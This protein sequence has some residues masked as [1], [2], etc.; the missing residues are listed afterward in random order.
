[1]AAGGF[2]KSLKKALCV[3][4]LLVV[5]T[6][7][8]ATGYPVQK[9][10]QKAMLVAA[11]HLPKP[12]KGYPFQWWRVRTWHGRYYYIFQSGRYEPLQQWEV[13]SLEEAFI[14]EPEMAVY[15]AGM[16]Q[17]NWGQVLDTPPHWNV[18]SQ[19]WCNSQR[20]P[21]SGTT[22]AEAIDLSE[23]WPG[24][25]KPARGYWQDWEEEKPDK[26]SWQH[27]DEEKPARG[28]WQDWEEEKPDKGSWQ[29][30]DE[31]ESKWQCSWQKEETGSAGASSSSARPAR[32][33]SRGRSPEKPEKGS[34]KASFS[35]RYLSRGYHS[36]MRREERHRYKQRGESIPPHLEV[37]QAMVC[38]ELKRAMWELQQQSRQNV[39]AT[40]VEEIPKPEQAQ[41]QPEE[42][43]DE[44][45]EA[46][47]EAM[48]ERGRSRQGVVGLNQRRGK[49]G[50]RSLTPCMGRGTPAKPDKGSIKEEKPEEME[51][52]QE[53]EQE[54]E[55]PE[56]KDG[57]PEEAKKRKRYGKGKEQPAE[58]PGEKDPPGDGGDGQP[59]LPPPDEMPPDYSGT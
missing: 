38:K 2:G 1:M 21:R 57:K 27:W 26:G 14:S 32:G 53:E 44:S 59:P 11:L 5:C 15:I 45:M 13:E 37:Q 7:K 4:L 39:R 33:H 56:E 24:H 48:P 19:Q 28:Y 35:K 18:D 54:E 51:D 22:M 16:S 31:N 47:D 20:Q 10:L 40:C 52:V 12:A 25:K 6:L 34:G 30:W 43:Q 50:P 49:L 29:D 9:S 8:P 36:Q 41:E 58:A 3:F 23:F 46:P 42:A 17:M 55:N